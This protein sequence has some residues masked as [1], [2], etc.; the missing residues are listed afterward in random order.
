MDTYFQTT[1]QKLNSEFTFELE[2]IV[3]IQKMKISDFELLLRSRKTNSF[4]SKIFSSISANENNNQQFL[5]WII[6]N[7]ILQFQAN[8]SKII[9]INL[10]P[11]QLTYQSTLACLKNLLPYKKQLIIE[12]T[13]QFLPLGQLDRLTKALKYLRFLDFKISLDDLGSGE[14]TLQFLLNNSV[15]FKRIKISLLKFKTLDTL[16]L[17]ALL[18]FWSIFAHKRQLELVVEGIDSNKKSHHVADKH[19]YLQQ[20]FQWKKKFNSF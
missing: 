1:V 20:G 12:L 9:A 11:L 8:P 3:N 17:D 10:D 15:Y 14:N 2:P 16:S 18:T 5:Q 19:I 4:P 13:E 7:L 6:N